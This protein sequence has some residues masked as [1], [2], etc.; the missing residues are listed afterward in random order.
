MS[1]LCSWPGVRRWT[2]G[3]KKAGKACRPLGVDLLDALGGG[4]A[5]RGQLGDL[6]VADDDVV[7]GVDAGDRIEHRGAAQDQVRA[8]PGAHLQLRLSSRRL[9]YRGRPCGA[10]AVGAG[11]G[12]S[13]PAA[14]SS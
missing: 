1:S 5:G 11:A 10:V 12:S 7:L 8:L 4:L 9:P 14:S 3:S 13:S 6:A 2:W